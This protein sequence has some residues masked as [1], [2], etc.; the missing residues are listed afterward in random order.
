M[1][2]FSKDVYAAKNCWYVASFSRDVTRSPLERWL[3]DQPV[4]LYRRENGEVVALEGRCAH[5][6]FPLAEGKVIGDNLQCPYHG[7]TYAP[8]GQ[9]VRIPSQERPSSRCGIKSYPT[10]EKWRWIWIWMGDPVLA[11]PGLIPDHYAIG[12]EGDDLTTDDAY[13]GE[14][15]A[16]YQLIHDN[17]MDLT[18]VAFLH[19][20]TLGGG[21]D[22][23]ATAK[24]SEREGEGWLEAERIIRDVPT[25]PH[26]AA[27]LGYAGNCDRHIGQRFYLPAL[28]HGWDKYLYPE[29][30]PEAGKMF[31]MLQVYH[32]ITP[33]RRNS[34]HYFFATARNFGREAHEEM[35]AATIAVIQEDV[36]GLC[37]VERML[38]ACHGN[39]PREYSARTDT[40]QLLA[41]RKLEQLILRENEALCEERIME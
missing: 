6:H 12:L 20:N 7:F 34:A 33:A 11:D 21:G 23:S 8:D 10:V 29:G 9:A 31:G 1:Y 36:W 26:F 13:H 5:R 14:I 32:A 41:R 30:H 19:R 24:V 40:Q 4:V 28:H 27:Y 18:H 17:L 37:H 3:L 25:V 2:P 15:E 35:R 39:V 22:D 38:Q 16:R